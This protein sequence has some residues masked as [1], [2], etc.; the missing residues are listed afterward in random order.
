MT[1]IHKAVE[2]ALYPPSMYANSPDKHFWQVD[3]MASV[4]VKDLFPTVTPAIYNYGDDLK[5]I[6]E[7][8]R[9]SLENVDMSMIKPMDRINITASEHGFGI[10]GGWPYLVMLKT[11]K[12]V[13]EERTGNYR[14]R[15]ILAMYRLPQESVEVKKYYDM[16]NYL[17]CEV[18]GTC[19]FDD[20]VEIETEVGKFYGN[21]LVYDCDWMVYAYY[22]DPREQYLHRC[23]NRLFKSFVMNFGRVETRCSF[24]MMS[25]SWNNSIIS[26]AIYDSEFVQKRWTFACIMNSSPAGIRG[27]YASN[28]LYECEKETEVHL[29]KDYTFVRLMFKDLD[30]WIAV[31]DGGKWGSYLHTAGMIY[32]CCSSA[33]TDYFDMEVPWSL[34][35]E[36]AQCE[37]DGKSLANKGRD[38][39]KSL[40]GIIMNQCWT[41]LLQMRDVNTFPVYC[42]GEELL[43]NFRNDR[44]NQG[45]APGQGFA[46]KVHALVPTLEDAIS[47]ATKELDCQ[48]VIA[49]DGSYDVINCSPS[50]AEDLIKKAQGVED[51]TYAV[52]LP[53]YLKQ[54]G[55]DVAQVYR[56]YYHREYKG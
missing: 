30:P 31:W 45:F 14:S 21:K 43:N 53:K 4:N 25:S 32:G 28:D 36:K 52:H 2:P 17:G 50:A 16:E 49:F 35:S 38:Y 23:V 48:N 34:A 39:V 46:D 54:R 7:A 18:I 3:G 6:E 56:D 24:H 44:V 47:M 12:N 20:G 40:K 37:C 33:G 15:V 19:P 41:G 10:M 29:M 42:V 26:Q 51:E 8:T 55:F 5:I 9:K 22:D 1:N 11:I 27:I 13:I